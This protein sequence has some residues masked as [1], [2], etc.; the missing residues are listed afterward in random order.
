MKLF[1]RT[2][3]P[4]SIDLPLSRK[5]SSTI[6]P[7][8]PSDPASVPS[9]ISSTSPPRRP[10][11]R[12]GPPPFFETWASVRFPKSRRDE[13]RYLTL[14]GPY[15]RT[16]AT[17]FGD[18]FTTVL[19]VFGATITADEF[20]SFKITVRAP[21][22]RLVILPESRPDHT[23]LVDHLMAAST[24]SLASCYTHQADHAPHAFGTI[25][26]ARDRTHDD[27]VTVKIAT[28]AKLPDVLAACARREAPLLLSLPIHPAIVELVDVYESDR[29]YYV[30]TTGAPQHTLWQVAESRRGAPFGERDV[31]AIVSALLGALLALRRAAVVHRAVAPWNVLVD[32]ISNLHAGKGKTSGGIEGAILTNFELACSV[33]EREDVPHVLA[34]MEAGHGMLPD[35]GLM[36]VA[37]EVRAGETCGYAGDV[38]SVGAVMHWMLVGEAPDRPAAGAPRAAMMRPSASMDLG[39]FEG[40]L[41]RGV[42]SGAKHLCASLLMADPRARVAASHALC[43][44]WLIL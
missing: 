36:F 32:G 41:W 35:C 24:R 33:S 12:H 21:T 26:Q 16:S 43:H 23:A 38:W 39:P 22:S 11:L 4:L 8:S 5:S 2:S 30:V 7:P 15:L 19:P 17:P 13:L 44:P 18:V 1:S 3:S 14:A 37:P 29:A 34:A 10:R 40:P 27:V 31:A 20:P 9:V 25:V 42:T 28:K 6:T